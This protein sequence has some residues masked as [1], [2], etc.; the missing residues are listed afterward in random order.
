[1]PDSTRYTVTLALETTGSLGAKLGDVT[2]KFGRAH[3]GA[4]RFNHAV[5]MT[6]EMAARGFEKV[7]HLVEE[8]A[9]KLIHVAEVGATVGAA[10][11]F[12]AAAYG[13]AHLN[14]EL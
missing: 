9:D 6:G 12:S 2:E 1:M 13:V 7:G 4:E 8:V 11:M 14:N 3:S 10:G 5:A